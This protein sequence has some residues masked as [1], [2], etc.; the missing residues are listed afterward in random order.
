MGFPRDRAAQKIAESQEKTFKGLQKMQVT[1]DKFL[2]CSDASRS[3]EIHLERQEKPGNEK[4][5]RSSARDEE[6]RES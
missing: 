1:I 5:W 2:D 4:T 6:G 3:S